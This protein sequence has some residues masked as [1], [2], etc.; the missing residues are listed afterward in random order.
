MEL[1][2]SLSTERTEELLE[3][4]IDERKGLVY[5]SDPNANAFTED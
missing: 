4:L 1:L 3:H 5:D 2:Y